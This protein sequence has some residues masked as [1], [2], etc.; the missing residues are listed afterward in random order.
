LKLGHVSA[1]FDIPWMQRILDVL[2]AELER[3]RELPA[4]VIRYLGSQYEVAREEVGPFLTGELPK[5]EEYEVDLILS[6]VFTPTIADQAIF[7]EALGTASIPLEQWPD[8]IQQILDQS[9]HAHLVTEDGQVHAVPLREVTI[10]RYVNRL[11]LGATI[12]EGLFAHI[13]RLNPASE[14]PLLKAV[15]RRAVWENESRRQILVR[16]LTATET[17]ADAQSRSE[18]ILELLKV[19]ETY[20]P[21]DAAELLGQIPHWE[22]VLR[23][24]S[25]QAS[26]SKPFFNE[27][28]QELHGGD[29]DQRRGEN[30]R[31]GGWKR[32]LSFLDRLK[33]I[34]S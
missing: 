6:P 25:Q 13:E 22:K 23:Q 1:L 32:E 5:L 30:P 26:N 33:R 28:V 17:G 18:D 29:R 4:Q 12:P 10:D 34:L 16:Y 8:L 14:R 7:A 24:E 11:R 15:A 27:R 21:A 3:S 31:L 9:S 19:M 20:K 2:K